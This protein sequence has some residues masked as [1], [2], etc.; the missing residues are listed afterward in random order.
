MCACMAGCRTTPAREHKRSG[1][2][3]KELHSA[4]VPSSPE[5]PIERHAG[6]EKVPAMFL[7]L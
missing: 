6:G 7:R 3:G 2:T 1:G 4:H 5:T